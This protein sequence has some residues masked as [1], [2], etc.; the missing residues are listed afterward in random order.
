MS[1]SAIGLL[2]LLIFA[3]SQ[4]VRDALFG[5]V[6]QS[7][8]FFLVAALTFGASTLCFS[9]LALLRQPKDF[10]K[11]GTSP[12]M[13]AALNVTTAVAWLSFFFGLKC[14]EPAVVATLYNGIGPLTALVLGGLGWI[15]A[16]GKPSIGERLCYVGLAGVL[17][18]LVFVVLT[19]R[20]GIIESNPFTQGAALLAVAVGGVTITISHLFARWFNDRGVGSDAVMGTR[21][22][23]TLC[24]S[25]A[26]EATIG[27]AMTRPPLAAVP[28][29]TLTA[30]AVV[31]IP[32]F[33]LQLGIA[34][35]S[36]LAVNIMRSLG[37]VSV[38]AVQQFDGRS[39]FSG[40]TLLC[41]VG[42]CIFAIAASVLRAWSEVGAG[43]EGH[44]PKRA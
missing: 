36:P 29:L 9:G 38:F 10:S 14:L 3:L 19:D 34:R 23:L 17:A 8:S 44:T 18:A 30:F 1:S 5:N 12:A 15:Q 4:G 16:K 2:Y 22:L 26:I 39:K 28:L 25:A 13:F 35:A 32:S 21:F 31:T 24:V 6:F 40:A 33:M 27:Q 43:S 42:F 11:L 37:P 7:I 20:S 41:I